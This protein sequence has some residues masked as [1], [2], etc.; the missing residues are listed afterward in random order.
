MSPRLVLYDMACIFTDFFNVEYNFKKLAEVLVLIFI[1]FYVFYFSIL[2]I[3][4]TIHVIGGNFIPIIL[5]L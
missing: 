1:K 4:L 2:H 5:R 3:F